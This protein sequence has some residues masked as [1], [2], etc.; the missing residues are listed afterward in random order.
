[1]NSNNGRLKKR[2]MRNLVLGAHVKSGREAWTRRSFGTAL[3]TAVLRLAVLSLLLVAGS[4]YTPTAQAPPQTPKP[5]RVL[6][7][8]NSY[9]YYNNLPEM[10]EQMSLSEGA[11]PRIQARMIVAGGATLG[12]HWQGGAALWSIQHGGWDLVVLQEQ[13]SL[14]PSPMVDGLPTIRSPDDFYKYARLFDEVIRQAGARTVFFSTWAR[15]NAPLQNQQALDYAYMRIARELHAQIAPVGLAWEDLRSRTSS[16]DPYSQDGSHPSPAG[17]YLAACVFYATLTGRNP[18]GLRS[19][20]SGSPVDETG[21]ISDRR[22]VQLVGLSASYA[23]V[24]QEAAWK[25]HQKLE[26]SGGYL[27]VPPPTEPLQ[28]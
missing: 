9:T 21:Q 5:L 18:R 23:Q 14:G 12:Q 17:S 24:I 27:N 19:D 25:A 6:F 11:V 2:E 22:K 3:R 13:S 28:I 8:G 4:N 15:R 10:L 26:A 1:M 20:I 16:V 7:V